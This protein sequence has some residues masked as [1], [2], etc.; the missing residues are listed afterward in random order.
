MQAMNSNPT[1]SSDP[2]SARDAETFSFPI[3]ATSVMLFARALGDGRAEY[4][5]ATNPAGLVPPPTFYQA[6]AHYEPDYPLDATRPGWQPKT[7]PRYPGPGKT[8]HGEQRFTYHHPV[9]SGEELTVTI[10]TGDQW[11]K[12]SSRG[13]ALDFVEQITEFRNGRG[14]LCVTAVNVGVIPENKPGRS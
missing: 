7:T 14:V 6:S 12:E 9:R 5:E 1:S 13:G 8:L 4:T 10:R 11:R 2:A 3:D